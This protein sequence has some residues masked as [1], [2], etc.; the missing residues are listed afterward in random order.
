MSHHHDIGVP[1]A[2]QLDDAVMQEVST[3]NPNAAASVAPNATAQDLPVQVETQSTPA[4]SHIAPDVQYVSGPISP[5]PKEYPM[6][7]AFSRD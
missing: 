5:M 7:G 1:P 6:P 4:V 2:S 3:A